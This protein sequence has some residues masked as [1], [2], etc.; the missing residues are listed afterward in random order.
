M[1]SLTCDLL[2][3][4][5]KNFS[6]MEQAHHEPS[7]YGITDGK[8]IGT[9]IE[10]KFKQFL[11]ERNYIFDAGN[12][13]SGIDFP[14]L[15]VDIKVTSI[16]QPQSSCPFTHARQKIY[17]LGYHLLLFIYHKE[18]EPLEKTAYLN[19]LHVI[20]MDKE[21][22]ADFQT[23]KSIL[24]IL[25]N[26]GNS[27]DIMAVLYERSLPIDDIEAQK[28][29]D[30]ILQN[31]PKQGYLTISNALQWRLQYKRAIEKAGI[32]EGIWKI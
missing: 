29:S 2:R 3:Q 11:Q 18:D 14:S 28:L 4:E 32:I 22:T 21:V 12:T 13:A 10:Q 9:Y 16:K 25:Q 19:I 8:A 24:N 7:L 27:D 31:P 5:A 15:G 26:E 30:D 1:K 17:G 6:V 23:T 20:F